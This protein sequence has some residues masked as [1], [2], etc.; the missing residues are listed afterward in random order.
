MTDTRKRD[1]RQMQ[2]ALRTTSHTLHHTGGIH[3]PLYIISVALMQL[4]H[5]KFAYMLV[6]TILAAI[7][8]MERQT[9]LWMGRFNTLTVLTGI[10]ETDWIRSQNVGDRIVTSERSDISTV[11]TAVQQE[12]A[13]V[14]LGR[15]YLQQAS[16]IMPR[17][18]ILGAE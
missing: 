4:I 18:L 11:S 6:D 17:M 14:I 16:I 1:G 12:T 10:L 2:P 7:I 5:I 9:I 15:P 13:D 3:A 8:S